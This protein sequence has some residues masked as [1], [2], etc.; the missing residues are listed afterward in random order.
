MGKVHTTNSTSFPR[1]GSHD[2]LEVLAEVAPSYPDRCR[3]GALV[4]MAAETLCSNFC[5]LLCCK[6]SS[7]FEGYTNTRFIFRHALETATALVTQAPHTLN[8]ATKLH[9]HFAASPGRPSGSKSD[10]FTAEVALAEK[11]SVIFLG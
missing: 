6:Q 9:Q 1:I 5:K 11:Q 10:L 3:L 2:L 4:N 7:K 8:E